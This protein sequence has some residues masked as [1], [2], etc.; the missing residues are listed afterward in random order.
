[1]TEKLEIKNFGPIVDV[2]IDL[3][4]VMVFI[5]NQA[6][7]KST[8]SKLIALFRGWEFIYMEAKFHDLLQH[9]SISSYLTLESYIKFTSEAFTFEL[10]NGECNLQKDG[11]HNYHITKAQFQE[12]RKLGEKLN[13]GAILKELEDIKSELTFSNQPQ[14]RANELLDKQKE[15]A[16]KLEQADVF[17]KSLV[18]YATEIFKLE[19]YSEYIPSERV[20]VSI[21]SGL[22]MNLLNNK[23]PLPPSLISFG[24]EFEKARTELK[25]LDIEF[26]GVKYKYENNEDRIYVGENKFIPFK[27]SASGFQTII[28]M[29]LVIYYKANE[30]QFNGR[31]FIVEEPELNLFPTTQKYLT[32]KLIEKCASYNKKENKFQNELVITTHSPYILSSLNNLLFSHRIFSEKPETMDKIESIIPKNSWINGHD[33]SAYSVDKGQVKSIIDINTSLISESELD[34]ASEK[35]NNDFD[36]LMDIY[37]QEK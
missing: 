32:Q 33:F 26:L 18:A 37:L 23:V 30:S 27:E 17:Q 22:F 20:F 6:T 11:N 16:S 19:N 35:I 24:A 2:N 31:T 28:P 36:I 15:L 5:G 7:G 1:M 12:Q 13:R 21:A 9:Y 29:L 34:S 10:S 3:K 14:E 25:S 8:I 4:P